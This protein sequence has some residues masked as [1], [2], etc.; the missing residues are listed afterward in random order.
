M[1]KIEITASEQKVRLDAFLVERYPDFSRSNLQQLIKKGEVLVNN[2]VKKAGYALR[3]GDVVTINFPEPIEV[4]LVPQNIPIKIV[5]QD[6]DLAVIDKPQ[7]LTVH[8]SPGHPDGTL[9]N[10][11]LYHVRD[12]SGING[13]L[14]PGIVHRLDK[15]TSGLMLVAKNDFAHRYLAQQIAQKSCIR[16]YIALLEGHFAYQ[17]YTLQTFFAR[18]T[19]DRKKMAVTQNPE[20]RIAKTTFL[21][22]EYF[23]GY[24]LCNCILGT[25]RTHQ[26]RVHAAYLGHPIVGDP[27]YGYKKQK[28]KLSGQLLHSEYIEFTHP[29]T[30]ERLSFY[31]ELPSYF[32][33]IVDTL[34]K[35]SSNS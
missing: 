16:R 24:T 18:S 35:K 7:G 4:S 8:P 20:D 33:K 12:L 15:D 5:Y 28:F 1:E 27:L 23:D 30:G 26:I 10:A 6:A 14:R 3:E 19:T 9:V 21:P 13:E 34:R 32:A 11:L 25:G 31:A 2:D 17:N 29:R 22:L